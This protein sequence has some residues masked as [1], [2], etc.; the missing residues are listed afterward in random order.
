MFLSM[1]CPACGRVLS[2]MT[3]EGIT[4]EVCTTGCAGIWFDRYELMKVDESHESAGEE[5]VKIEGD[6]EVLGALDH[7]KRLSCPQTPE[8]VMMRHFFSV[9]RQVSVD[10]CPECGGYWL[11]VGELAT[12]RTEFATEEER[13]QAA[14]QYFSELFDSELA[15]AH[16]ETE[17][18]LER[19]R[20]IAY[21]FRF[22][23]PSYYI[24]GKQE[25][26]AF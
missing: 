10:E 13:D 4:V 8:V 11:D 22:I 20:R 16:S 26:G 2:P 9:K 17:E 12:I 15:A 1:R 7:T 14:A 6:P 24:P 23:S 25:W 3:V 18:D 21:I 19:A 5:L